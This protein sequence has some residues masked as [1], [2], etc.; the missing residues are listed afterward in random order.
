MIIVVPLS[1]DIFI[2]LLGIKK[3]LRPIPCHDFLFFLDFAIMGYQS[4]YCSS[5]IASIACLHIFEK[6]IIR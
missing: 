5:L 2:T 1:F 6:K 3:R 4:Q